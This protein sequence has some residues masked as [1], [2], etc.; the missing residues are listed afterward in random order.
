[1]FTRESIKD[2]NIL[3]ELNVGTNVE[4]W[5]TSLKCGIRVMQ[6]PQAYYVGMSERTWRKKVARSDLNKILYKNETTFILEK[7]VPKL[8]GVFNVLE[9][10]GVS[11]Y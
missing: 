10:Y 5:I 3:K 9:R 8:K 11:L 7:Y 4:T 6:E 2:Q 1:M